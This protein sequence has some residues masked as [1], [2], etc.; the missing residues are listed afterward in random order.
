MLAMTDLPPGPRL[1]VVA[2]AH[3]EEDNVP[4]L[5][6]EV[7]G[8]LAPLAAESG[9]DFE[10]ILVDDGSTDGTRSV[11]QAMMASRP[12]LRC[13]AM[14]ETPPGRGHG[15]SAAFH[16]GFRACR[17]QWVATLDA[18]CQ[19]DPADLP[20]MLD[21]LEQ[22]GADMVQ[23]DR[24]AN[25][26]DSPVRRAGSVVGRAFR[27]WILRDT[28]RDTGC[29][30]RVMRREIAVRLPL[31]FR[32]MHR[33]IPVT[34]R[35]LGY[36]VVEM[37]VNHRPRTA[38]ETKYG[39]GI[40]SRALPGLVDCF[41]VRYM[42]AR[43]RPVLCEVIDPAH[44]A[45]RRTEATDAIGQASQQAVEVAARPNAV[46]GKGVGMAPPLRSAGQTR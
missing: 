15:Q 32:G 39:M 46:E 22:T 45:P 31:E 28:I 14:A 7:G 25:R 29:S 34:A 36:Q 30:L 4:R 13:L 33:F 11:V 8:A 2:P 5:V 12:W 6:E 3:N 9:L 27:R 35:Q 38:G 18:D 43:R 42:G 19:N 21:L 37:P 20:R 1:S 17:G 16:A 40:A 44:D 26:Q 24:S 41:A 10:F 23:G